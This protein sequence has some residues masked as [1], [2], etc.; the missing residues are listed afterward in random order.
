MPPFRA[1]RPDCILL[2][3][4]AIPAATY[5]ELQELRAKSRFATPHGTI[6]YE[7]GQHYMTQTTEEQSER[8]KAAFEEWMRCVES[9][10]T[11]V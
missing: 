1:P 2:P 10:T 11:V 6:Y 7:S 3:R 4:F 8:E 9:Q 5:T